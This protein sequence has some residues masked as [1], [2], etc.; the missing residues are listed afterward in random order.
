MEPRTRRQA[1]QARRSRDVHGSLAEQPKP[2]PVGEVVV[3]TKKCFYG[4]NRYREGQSFTI[5]DPTHFS[6][7]YMRRASDVEAAEAAGEDE[8]QPAPRGK[9]KAVK[10]G[11][12]NTTA[13]TGAQS[14]IE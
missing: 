7:N 8:V 9:K 6:K 14:V 3:A 2:A 12:A 4:G 13:P 10:T 1:G 5:S 11:E